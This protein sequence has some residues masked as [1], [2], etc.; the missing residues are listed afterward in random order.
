MD[1]GQFEV[2]DV[3]GDHGHA[4]HSRRCRDKR[5]DHREG[6]RVLLTT[7][8]GGDGESDWENSVFEPGLHI[9]ESALEGGGL[10]LVSPAANSRDSLFDLAQG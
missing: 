10:V 8:G 4:V 7:P 3:A 5:V 2:L 9:P 6:L 1:S